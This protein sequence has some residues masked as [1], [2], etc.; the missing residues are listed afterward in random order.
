MERPLQGLQV[1][2]SSYAGVS[3][4]RSEFESRGSPADV[5]EG[6]C[7]LPG[8]VVEVELWRSVCKGTVLDECGGLR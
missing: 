1:K 3:C 4:R 5:S 8:G 6:G 7:S 2:V